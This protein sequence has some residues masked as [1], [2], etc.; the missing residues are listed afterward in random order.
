[1]KL[2][3]HPAQLAP[4]QTAF[5]PSAEALAWARRVMAAFAAA[6]EAGVLALDG[7]M[8]DR[9]HRRLAERILAAAG[10]PPPQ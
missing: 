4:V 2:C 1:G 6:P 5:T 3:I 7:R 8:I 10:E 9:P